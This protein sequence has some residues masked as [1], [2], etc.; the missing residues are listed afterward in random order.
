MANRLGFEGALYYST[1]DGSTSGATLIENVMD[2]EMIVEAD[3]VDKTT[4]NDGGWRAF[5]QGLKKWGATATILWDAADA[6]IIALKNAFISNKG[7]IGM[8]VLDKARASGGEGF[9]GKAVITK[10]GRP[11]PLGDN[12][13]IN[14]EIQGDGLPTWGS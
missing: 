12:M 7:K 4:R 9:S 10:F 14:V 2:C 8:S 6:D 3:A 13:V 1:A 5:Q 11:E